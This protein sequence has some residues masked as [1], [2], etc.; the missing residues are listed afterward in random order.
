MLISIVVPAY[1]KEKLIIQDISN[2]YTTMS[3]TRFDFEIIVVEDGKLDNT[4]EVFSA[5]LESNPQMAKKVLLTGYLHNHGKGYA[6]RYGMARTT[7]D[8]VAF[9]D[10]GME[11][12][13]SGISMLL[14]HMLWYNADIVVGSKRHPASKTNITLMRRLY[15]WGYYTGV[16]L[17]FGLRITDTQTGIK[18]FKREVLEKVLPRLVVKE[19]AFDIEVLS[20]A[21]R[22]GY[23][24]IFDAP[25]EIDLKFTDDSKL[26]KYKPLF[27]DRYVRG[28]LWDTLAVFYRLRLLQYYDDL[29]SR[30]WVFDE[31]LLLRVNT[32]E[33][34]STK[35]THE[36]VLT[37]KEVL[38]T[39]YKFSVII[40]VR[41]VNKHLIQNAINLQ[42]LP[43]KNFEVLVLTDNEDS[44]DFKDNRFKII[45]CGPIG[46]GE[47]RNI[48]A[49][50]ASGE[51][52][53]FLDDDAYPSSSWLTNAAKVFEDD[54]VYALGAPAMTPLGVGFLERCS[55]KV[56]ESKLTSG[57]TNHI[58]VP[59]QQKWVKDHPSVNFFVRKE[60][61]IEVGGFVTEFWPG[62]DTKLCLELV[63]NNN[64]D[65]LYD[66]TPIVFHH[67]R[68]L[69]RPHL[70]Q[71]SRYGQHRGQFARIFPETSRLP[72]YF[73]PSLFVL[74]LVFTPLLAFYTPLLLIPYFLTLLI[75]F[76]IVT[77]EST[78]ASI[79]EHNLLVFPFV[80][81]GIFLTHVVY[82][83]YFII[84]LIRKP[85]LQLKNFNVR[86][87]SYIGG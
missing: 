81:A 8:Y 80:G 10:S 21:H 16:K 61:F 29:S 38:K 71:Y 40:P 48:G 58:H 31:D 82:G 33:V 3:K 51:I 79:E 42:A 62:E 41:S 12:N 9:I 75:Y 60:K 36:A 65:I 76:G 67:R 70:K 66:P 78:K 35:S 63:K 50:H 84:G 5:Y 49:Q 26:S 55:G 72:Q 87:G 22:L 20:V 19:F 85:K 73:I 68:N 69:F 57:A 44:Y 37:K 6:V 27:L 14:E 52:L 46:P 25:V 2:L 24:R 74:G 18:V 23:T 86:T 13:P 43:F 11:I 59:A 83:V 39:A 77:Y 45:A 30:Q 54:D 32:G 28:V 34:G 53:A 1:K 17:L 4:K 64:K 15:S 56:L 47:K 7:G